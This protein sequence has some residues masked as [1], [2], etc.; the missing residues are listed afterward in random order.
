MSNFI[1]VLFIRRTKECY[2][3]AKTHM[4]DR[5]P[6]YILLYINI[7]IYC[8]IKVVVGHYKPEKSVV[9]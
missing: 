9:K 7:I 1:L 6:V 3:S 4:H 8:I 5:H 2:S